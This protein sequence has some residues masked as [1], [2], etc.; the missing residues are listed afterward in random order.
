MRDLHGKRVFIT[1]GG[2][3]LGRALAGRFADAGAHV[4]VTDRDLAAAEAVA[5]DF[6][7]AAAFRLDV[8]EL[9]AVLAVRDQILTIG[10]IDVLVN[11][12]GVV[13]GGPF[14]DVSLE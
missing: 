3:G 1:G 10:P 13:F 7:N 12:A 5:G 4:I 8:T 6:K 11:N 9:A 14:A 2:G